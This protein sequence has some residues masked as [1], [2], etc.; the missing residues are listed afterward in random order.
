MTTD[1]TN[2]EPENCVIFDDETTNPLVTM[3]HHCVRQM[4]EGI[5]RLKGA[6]VRVVGF[7]PIF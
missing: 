5:T 4:I 2:C 7:R 1:Y 6:E 3:T